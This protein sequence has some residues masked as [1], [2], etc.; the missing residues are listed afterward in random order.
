MKFT[1]LISLLLLLFRLTARYSVRGVLFDRFT[2]TWHSYMPKADT[3][4]KSINARRGSNYFDSIVGS[5]SIQLHVCLNMQV[6]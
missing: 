6:N 2:A 1:E 3:D 4:R 5:K